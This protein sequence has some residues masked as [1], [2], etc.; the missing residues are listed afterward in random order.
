[1]ARP[2]HGRRTCL[3]T[4]PGTCHFIGLCI[5]MMIYTNVTT[6]HV[7]TVLGLYDGELDSDLVDSRMVQHSQR[8][9]PS[10][11]QPGVRQIREPQQKPDRAL[12]IRLSVHGHTEEGRASVM[13]IRHVTS[14]LHV[15]HARTSAVCLNLTPRRR[16]RLWSWT[17][18]LPR[19]S[20]RFFVDVLQADSCTQGC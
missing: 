10:L 9:C 7:S 3:T 12:G 14:G 11:G 13:S 19:A 8:L 1:M 18:D 2:P 20:S 4:L 16:S 15:P 5:E 6:R 17:S